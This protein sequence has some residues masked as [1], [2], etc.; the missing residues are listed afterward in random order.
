MD[1]KVKEYVLLSLGSNIG[2]RKKFIDDACQLLEIRNI[3]SNIQISSYYETEPFGIK[4]QDAFIN[5]ALSGITDLSVFELMSACKQIE[6]DLGRKKREHWHER[7][8]DID[9]LIY[10]NHI[11]SSEKVITPHPFLAKRKFVLIPAAEIAAKAVDPRTCKTISE[12]LQECEDES[13]VYK[14]N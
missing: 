9:I 12:L 3:L 10:G 7:E 14:L 13:E 2:N 8:I 1:N 11:I 5:L 4:E 6:S